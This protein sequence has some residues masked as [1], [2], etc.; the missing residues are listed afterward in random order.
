MQELIAAY[1]EYIAL[2]EKSEKGYFSLAYAHGYRCPE[3][4]IK[5]GEELRA[6]IAR[7]KTELVS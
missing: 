4:L 3:E 6:K 1:D 2:L 5:Q 7:L